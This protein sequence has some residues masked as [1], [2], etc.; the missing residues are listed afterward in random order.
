MTV[1]ELDTVHVS[2][3]DLA[4]GCQRVERSM[5]TGEVISVRTI[6]KVRPTGDG[7]GV[8]FSFEAAPDDFNAYVVNDWAVEVV[9]LDHEF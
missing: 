7:R 5:H 9:A 8:Q 4:P 2:G 1:S 3:R 6:A